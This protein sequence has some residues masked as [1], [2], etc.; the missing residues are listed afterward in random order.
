MANVDVTKI[1]QGP[2]KLWLDLTVPTA[3]NRLIIDASGNWTV[4]AQ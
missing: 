4:V 3:G 1:H 2:G